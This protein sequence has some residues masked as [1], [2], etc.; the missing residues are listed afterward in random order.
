LPLRAAHALTTAATAWALP[1]HGPEQ[2]HGGSFRFGRVIFLSPIDHQGSFPGRP[3]LWAWPSRP[4]ISP[5]A[6]QAP[7]MLLNADFSALVTVSA[8]TDFTFIHASA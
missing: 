8:H 4:A 6:Q 2:V 5:A 7:S 1:T 3:V